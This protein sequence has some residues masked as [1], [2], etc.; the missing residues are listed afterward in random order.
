MQILLIEDLDNKIKAIEEFVLGN[1]GD[2]K[3]KI[4]YANC[5]NDARRE[6]IRKKFDL[7]IFDIFLPINGD[8]QEDTNDISSDLIS[9]FTQSKNYQAET[10]AITKYDTDQIENM[11]LFNEAGVTVVHYSD[12]NPIWK[13]SLSSKLIKI[14]D[15]IEY[16]FLIF[17]ALGKE[18]AAY[19]K[20]DAI[21]GDNTSVNGMD[22]QNLKIDG[23]SG[24]CIVPS[25]MGLVN[26]AITATK[27]IEMFQPKIVA[28]SGICA[29]VNGEANFLDIVV[30]EPCWEYQTGKFKDNTFKQE[31][32]QS[33]LEHSIKIDLKQFCESDENL[34]AIKSGLYQTE[35]S[36]SKMFLAPMSSGS[37]VIADKNKMKE[38]GTQHRKMAALEMEMYSLYEAAKQSL[39]KPLYFGAKAVVDMGES[40]KDDDYHSSGTVVSARFVVKFL[41]EKM[42]SLDN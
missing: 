11:R 32:Y 4:T 27:A 34:N 25:N 1:T 36:N 7:I 9:E 23:Y 30:G 24:L 10:I 33:P 14:A 22:C 12:D 21:V 17:C 31:P 13:E 18:R 28:M 42:P 20:T 5:L 15:K 29:G 40:S 37:A 19:S 35:L 2:T 41:S 16:D 8:S 38:I 6:I 26:M 3:P 39:S